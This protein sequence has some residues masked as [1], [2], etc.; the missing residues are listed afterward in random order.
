MRLQQCFPTFLRFRRLTRWLS[1]C[2]ALLKLN[3]PN[4]ILASFITIRR[5]EFPSLNKS[6]VKYNADSTI[7]SPESKCLG[8]NRQIMELKLL[9]VHFVCG[10][11]N[12]S[13]VNHPLII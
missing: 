3:L 10:H 13:R 4:T 9:F 6:T 7:V 5:E 2:S 12:I 1:I 11:L 8:A